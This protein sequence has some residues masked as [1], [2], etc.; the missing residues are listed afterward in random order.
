ML[1]LWIKSN[2]YI[3]KE[4]VSQKQHDKIIIN[5][6]E[7]RLSS[8]VQTV[9]ICKNILPQYHSFGEPSHN[10]KELQE[11]EDSCVFMIFSNPLVKRQIK[12]L[13][14]DMKEYSY[15]VKSILLKYNIPEKVINSCGIYDHVN[16]SFQPS[17]DTKLHYVLKYYPASN[18]FEIKRHDSKVNQGFKFDLLSSEIVRPLPYV[19][20]YEEGFSDVEIPHL[21]HFKEEIT[22]CYH[23]LAQLLIGHV[24]SE[25]I[26]K[27]YV[28]GT[29]FY[30]RYEYMKLVNKNE[31][32][33]SNLRYYDKE[34]EQ[35]YKTT[36][37]LYNDLVFYC[38]LACIIRQ[39]L[40]FRNVKSTESTDFVKFYEN[41]GGDG[42]MK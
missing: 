27:D 41:I 38:T 22:D 4:D 17:T 39:G 2:Q 24:S 36:K 5:S 42:G 12:C 9:D 29:N 11:I 10:I 15:E 33:I 16:L 34:L 31:A 40:M 28:E 18:F 35:Y 14:Y 26:F 20:K 19:R 1:S 30:K 37:V 3:K 13:L 32:L 8:L 7:Q 21:T 25:K 23:E 6:I